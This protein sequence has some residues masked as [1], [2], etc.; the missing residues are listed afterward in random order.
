VTITANPLPGWTFEGWTGDHVG[1]EPTFIWNVAG[2]ATFKANYDTTVTATPTGPGQIVLDPTL[3]RYPYGSQVTVTPKPDFGNYFALWGGD[4]TG[5]PPTAFTLTVTNADIKIT[6]LFQPLATPAYS[7]SETR[8]ENSQLK[9]H[10]TGT[11]GTTIS[12]QSTTDFIS[13]IDR[14]QITLQG[15]GGMDVVIPFDTNASQQF[16]RVKQSQ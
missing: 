15:T 4:A 6:G 3:P 12:V 7:I 9:F 13:W 11:V 2:N 8:I 5:H 14:Q 10:I 1:A 16:I